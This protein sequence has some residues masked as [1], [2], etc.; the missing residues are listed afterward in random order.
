MLRRPGERFRKKC[1]LRHDR[2]GGGSVM[3]WGG[4]TAHGRTDLVFMNGT[5]NAQKYRHFDPSCC[6]IYQEKWRYISAGQ[7]PS[8]CCTGQYGLSKME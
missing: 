4:I 6:S 5:L 1:V 3:V 7:R 2:Y 8:T